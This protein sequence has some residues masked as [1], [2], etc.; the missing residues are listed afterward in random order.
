MR[1][2]GSEEF[3]QYLYADQYLADLRRQQELEVRR[4]YN[5]I[6]PTRM[7]V[8]YDTG[9][10][11]S[12]STSVENYAIWLVEMKELQSLQ[13][14]TYL[15]RQRVFKQACAVLSPEEIKIL[16]QHKA[17]S[18]IVKQHQL[19]QVFTKLKNELERLVISSVE[20]VSCSTTQMIAEC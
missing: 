13:L 19:L 9:K 4:A 15:Q 2:M 5:D 3:K 6:S 1:F 14:E 18:Q 11:Y 10:V 20:V 8:D 12:E 7:M 17:R 16:E